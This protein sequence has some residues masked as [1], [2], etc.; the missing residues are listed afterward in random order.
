MENSHHPS[1]LR[2]TDPGTRRHPWHRHSVHLWRGGAVL[3]SVLALWPTLG[4]AQVQLWQIGPGQQTWDSQAE[5]QVGV[6]AS[7]GRLQPL[8]VLPGQNLTRLLATSG[9]AWQNN[10]PEDYTLGGLPRVWTNSSFFNSLKGPLALV[11]GNDTTSTGTTFI[12]SGN[13]AGTTFFVDLGASFPVD[14]LRF[15]PTLK[16]RDAYMRAYQISLSA[17]DE[18]LSGRPVYSLLRRVE[19]NDDATVALNFQAPDTRFIQ[20]KN[21][22]KAPFNL[23]EIEVYGR[24]YVS[25]GEYVSKLHAFAQP[26]NYGRLLVEATRLSTSAKAPL[27]PPSAVIQLRSGADDS[28]LNYYRRDRATGTETEVTK[29]EYDTRLPRLAYF[30]Q[31]AVTGQVV[32]EVDRTEYQ[33]LPDAERGPMRDFV[34]GAIRVDGT[35]W[36]AWSAPMQVD[37]TGSYSFP[38]ELP[39]PRAYLQVRIRFSG[40]QANAIRLD[41]FRLEYSPLLASDVVGEVALASTP[42]PPGGITMVPAAVETTFTYDLKPTFTQDG[43]EGFYGLRLGALPPPTFVGFE[44]GAGLAAVA[45]DSV[46]TTNQGFDIFFAPVTRRT[47]QPL[48]VTFHQKVLE[49]STPISAWLLGTRGGL[50]QPVAEGNAN[51]AVTTNT[52]RVYTLSPKPAIEVD[53]SAD[54]ITPNGDGVNDVLKVT[55]VLIQFTAGVQLD[56]DIF[57]LSGQ[58]IRRL[59]SAPLS[60]GTYEQAWD[61][62]DDDGKTVPPGT[63]VCRVQGEAQARTFTTA[64]AVGVAY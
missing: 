22:D 28:P 17:G 33:A 53:L 56:V 47:A 40:D 12:S 44:V 1:S 29:S 54:V 55:S 38:I 50:P 5:S 34:Q 11:D 37:S 26:A 58:R 31:D 13:P 2:S 42:A 8:R 51:D 27:E 35:N 49:H 7:E 61:G 23:A 63:Y 36:S 25:S 60:A 43:L 19:N 57:D 41:A 48:R 20:I 3:L 24:G 64:R 16:Q 4:A 39:S 59:F 6:A 52:Q 14:S 30:R 9:Q 45:P 21:L 62:R 15:Y 46:R 32:A 10:A 18:F